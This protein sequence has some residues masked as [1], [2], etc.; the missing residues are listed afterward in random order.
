MQ[1]CTFVKNIFMKYISRL[2]E[3]TFEE[4]IGF[5]P[6]IAVLGPRQS[7]KSTLIKE[8]LKRNESSIYLDLQLESDR[9]KL[10]NPEQYFYFNENKQICLDEIQRVPEIFSTLRSVIDKDRRP[11][12]FI[13]LGSAS[14]ELIKQSSESL[15]GRIG[16]LE[17]SPFI[18]PEVREN[19]STNDLWIQ[20]GFPDSFLASL[21]MSRNWRDNFIR[22]FLERDIPQI[23][24]SIPADTIGRLWKMLAHNHGQI[25]N[26]SNLGRSLGTSH[27]TVRNYIDLLNQTFMTREL[28]PLESNIGKRL[29]KSS[30]LY[31]RDSGILHSLLNISDFEEL[32]SH[33]V[34]GFSWEG[35]V[36]ENICTY[37]NEFDAFFYKTSQGAELDLVLVKGNRK[38]AFEFKVADAPKPTKG[39]WIALEDVK[40][41]ITFV[42]SPLADEYPISENVWGIGMQEL[43]KKLD[44]YRD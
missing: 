21:K 30:K 25:L 40:P 39:F 37:L 24:F 31:I 14:R 4:Y 44:Q 33:P 13:I 43:F 10:S 15:A 22:T 2:L 19:K 12:R 26:L 36:I 34:F 3:E 29:I 23:G 27:T 28:Q 41:E 16:Y 20:G 5:F 9:Q 32:V 38:I 17:L 42:V 18:Y 6:A 35:L 8:Y 7:G 1:N 11:G